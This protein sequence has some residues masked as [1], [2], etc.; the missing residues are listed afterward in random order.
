M[1]AVDTNII[2]R[3]LVGDDPRQ[4]ALATEAFASHQ[5]F[6]SK[7][8]LLETE[9]VLRGVYGLNPEMI[10]QSILGI[11]GLRNV[12]VED[13]EVVSAAMDFIK[14]GLDFADAFHLASRPARAHFASFDRALV[15][16]AKR[17][18]HSTVSDL[19]F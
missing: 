5:I 16:K 2:V 3:L 8:V 18:G 4:T 13:P 11:L 6:I 9:W 12:S 1:L 7:T 10:R 15:R 19:P 17:L 14:H